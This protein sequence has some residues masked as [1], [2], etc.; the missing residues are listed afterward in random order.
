MV[1]MHIAPPLTIFITI[2]QHAY[3]WKLQGYFQHLK[4]LLL[5]P[6][7]M[8]CWGRTWHKAFCFQYWLRGHCFF[9]WT[10]IICLILHQIH[11]QPNVITN[12]ISCL[13]HIRTIFKYV[14]HTCFVF[15]STSCYASWQTCVE[16]EGLLT[17]REV[18]TKRHCVLKEVSRFEQEMRGLSHNQ[19]SCGFARLTLWLHRTRIERE[20]TGKSGI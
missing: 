1:G 18:L 11:N 9:K 6:K 8:C 3:L 7:A 16:I 19:T 13:R 15:Y 5:T 4:K 14:F 17:L 20:S 2:W 10:W 12:P